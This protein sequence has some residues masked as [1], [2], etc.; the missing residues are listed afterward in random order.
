MFII[1]SINVMVYLCYLFWFLDLSFVHKSLTD[2]LFVNNK[3]ADDIFTA[4]SQSK[5]VSSEDNVEGFCDEKNH[6][7]RRVTFL[8]S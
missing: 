6:I 2:S 8:K 3:A 4:A 1:C 7:L 5:A